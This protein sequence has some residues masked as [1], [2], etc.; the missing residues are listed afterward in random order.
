MENGWKLVGLLVFVAVAGVLLRRRFLTGEAPLRDWFETRVTPLG[1]KL[2]TAFCLLTL[3]IWIALWAAADPDER[4]R[5]PREFQKV[6]KSMEWEKKDK[7]G[8]GDAVP[9]PAQ[10]PVQ[11]PIPGAEGKP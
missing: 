7:A 2:F 5:L 8:D 11:V 9:A 10:S 1:G 4:T 3:V 6:L